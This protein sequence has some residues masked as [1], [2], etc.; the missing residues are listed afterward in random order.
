[1]VIILH[2]LERQRLE[3]LARPMGAHHRNNHYVNKP[4]TY[5][6]LFVHV[7]DHASPGR[8]PFPSRNSQC[9]SFVLVQ[10]QSLITLQHAVDQIAQR[11]PIVLATT[12][13][14]TVLIN[15]E[16]IVLEAGVEM[17]LQTE[18][19]DDLVVVAVDVC[20]NAVEALEQLAHC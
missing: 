20:V 10:L 6:V 2:F 19:N 13:L 1:M 8:S 16:D 18:M 12:L 3:S 11:A 17:R 14:E 4:P 9:H 7:Q 5:A 15:E